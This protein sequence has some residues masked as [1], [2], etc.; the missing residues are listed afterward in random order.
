MRLGERLV[1]LGL[2]SGDQLD[3]ALRERHQGDRLLGEIFVDLGFITQSA[4]SAVLAEST[5]LE[6]FDPAT[7][8]YDSDL[9]E[10]VPKEIALKYAVLPVS[11]QGAVLRA[12]MADPYDVLALDQLRRCFANDVEIQPLLTSK[13]DLTEAIDN[14]YGYEM[15]IDGILR[16]IETGIVDMRTMTIED[17]YINPT[18]RLVSAIIMDSVKV[19]ASDIHFEPEGVFVRLRYRVD[20]ALTQIRTFHKDYWPAISVRIKIIA[21]MNIADIRNPQDGRMTMTVAGREVDFRVASHPTVHGENIVVRVLDKHKSLKPLEQLGFGAHNLQVLESLLTRPEGIVVIT[22]PTG[23]GKTTT[24]YAMLQKINSV[25]V[26]IMTLEDPVEYEL[27]RVRQSHI[28]ESAGMT[29]GEGVRSILRQDPDI[30]FIGE[31]RDED[32]ATMALRAAM[33]GHQVYTTLH[34]ND[35]LGAIPRLLDLDLRPSIL[36]GHI[37]GILAQRLLRVL[38]GSCKRARSAT[39]IECQL[40]DAD[41]N[42]APTVYEAV[43]CADCGNKG[44]RGR[45]AVIEILDFDDELDELVARSAPRGD[46]LKS[47]RRRGFRTLADDGISKVLDGET[48]IDE[49]VKRVDVTTR[50]V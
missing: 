37:I 17:G 35:A 40:L 42:A 25:D 10:R 46:L 3:V 6:Q 15:S 41:V 16:E 19:G 23:S 38:C 1:D 28:R 13:S 7:A 45:V 2:I 20:G 47:A 14:F 27:P 34:T 33:A 5:G 21:G 49:L 29:F 36:S 18:V 43:G 48:S 11:L 44:Y 32:T 8:V 24:L 4:L 39:P 31:V 22:G 9:I 30:V 50:P 12:A 26:N